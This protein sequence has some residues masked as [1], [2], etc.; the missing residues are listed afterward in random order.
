M[1][2]IADASDLDEELYD[3]GEV[4]T[5]ELRRREADD[6]REVDVNAPATDPTPLPPMVPPRQT[7]YRYQSDIENDKLVEELSSMLMD[8]T[9]VQATPAHILAASPPIRK[10]LFERICARRVESAAFVSG[11]HTYEPAYSLPLQEVDVEVGGSSIEAGVLDPGSQIVAICQDLAE[12]VGAKINE[13]VKIEMEGA[14]GV[15]SWTLGCAEN[16]LMRIGNV[17][18]RIHAHV[19]H[20]A[21]FRLLLGRPCQNLLLSNLEERPDGR[22]VVSI[23]DPNDRSRSIMVPTRDRVRETG[24]LRVLTLQHAPSRM[25]RLE[26]RVLRMGFQDQLELSDSEDEQTD[27]EDQPALQPTT[28]LAYKRVAQKVRPVPT[29]SP[30]YPPYVTTCR[31]D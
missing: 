15:T 12:E 3:L 11:G 14:N 16:L 9:L 19:V 2:E 8:G 17:S 22:V 24:R 23:R 7:Q 26:R 27:S 28:V 1:A 5:A 10:W 31:C 6:E 25:K 20:E 29:L 21:P 13:R 30:A 4:L 18:F